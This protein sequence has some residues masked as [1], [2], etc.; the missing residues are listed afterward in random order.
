MSPDNTQSTLQVFHVFRV[1][2]C[3]VPVGQARTECPFIRGWNRQTDTFPTCVRPG[4]AQITAPT[5]RESEG[6][7]STDQPSHPR[8]IGLG[9]FSL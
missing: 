6:K 1:V 2:P 8:Y 9:F 7:I 4:H 5:K 3:R